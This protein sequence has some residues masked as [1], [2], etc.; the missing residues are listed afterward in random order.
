M[1]AIVETFLW[2]V[3][4]IASVDLEISDGNLGAYL[5]AVRAKTNWT[6]AWSKSSSAVVNCKRI[7]TRLQEC[8][9]CSIV[10][11]GGGPEFTNRASQFARRVIYCQCKGIHLEHHHPKELDLAANLNPR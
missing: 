2:P 5:G 4:E 1:A 11:F 9:S 8:N 7:E 6:T 3:W 10:P